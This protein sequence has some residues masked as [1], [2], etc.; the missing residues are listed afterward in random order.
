MI[1]K[2]HEVLLLSLFEGTATL[3]FSGKQSCPAANPSKR[4]WDWRAWRKLA[5]VIKEFQPDLIQANAGGTL[6]YA[7]CS[8]L[9]FRWKAKL[10]FRN[11]NLISAFYNSIF[12]KLYNSFLMRN[13]DGVASV[14]EF[15]K[16][17]FLNTFD[18]P[19]TKIAT[20]PIGVNNPNLK[21]ELPED[22][23]EKLSGSHFLIHI[24]SF[25]PEKDHAGLIMI[26]RQ[27]QLAYP[28]LRLLLVGEGRLKA[29]LEEE[30]KV[31]PL[32]Y[33]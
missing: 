10:V 24:G 21:P 5:T 23:K 19:N 11:A 31:M 13:I 6:K 26:F 15:C 4:F 22:V 12:Q 16:T 17:D 32:L 33:L 9:V 29:E 30:R 7:I 14:S 27:I 8:K 28:D 20:L 1:Q 25:V 18:F 2:G 3:P